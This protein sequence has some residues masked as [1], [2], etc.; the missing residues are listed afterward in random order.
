MEPKVS[1]YTG[2]GDT[3][4]GMGGFMETSSAFFF[5]SVS[6]YFFL[7]C[8][9]FLFPFI[10]LLGHAS[11]RKPG[12]LTAGKGARGRDRR[13]EVCLGSL[14]AS[15]SRLLPPTSC[16]SIYWLS[17]PTDHLEHGDITDTEPITP[18]PFPSSPP[19]RRRLERD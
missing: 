9:I 10:L 6:F 16:L 2:R 11:E 12:G 18:P 3:W 4:K 7:S 19:R 15:R 13:L 1:I 17:E 5:C 8:F 14:I